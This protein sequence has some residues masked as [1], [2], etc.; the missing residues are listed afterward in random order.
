MSRRA[1]AALPLTA[2]TL[3][4]AAA[5]ASPITSGTVL[6]K[7]DTPAHYETIQVPQYRTQCDI[8][9]EPEYVGGTTTEEP[10]EVCTQVFAYFLPV[11]NWIPEDRELLVKGGNRTGWADVTEADYGSAR[12]G[13][14]WSRS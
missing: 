3:V 9:E 4:L 7:Q 8:E 1:L 2:A 11:T 13:A 14:Y 10:E 12:P 5:C 6:S